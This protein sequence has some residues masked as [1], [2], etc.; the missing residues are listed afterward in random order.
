M[1]IFIFILS[2]SVPPSIVNEGTVEDLKVKEKQNIF[3][4]CEVTGK[5]HKLQDWL[6]SWSLTFD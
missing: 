6:L 2:N 1:F 4:A 3:L 5:W